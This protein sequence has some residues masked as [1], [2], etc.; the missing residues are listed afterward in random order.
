GRDWQGFGPK[1]KDAYVAGFIAGAAVRGT[2]AASGID[3]MP[4]KA[5]DAMRT[6][7]QMPF[8]FSVSVYASQIDDYYWW[9]NHL[10]IPIVDVMVRTNFQLHSH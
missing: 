4:S 3:T 5:I 1:E 2:A 7:K 9:E 10:D 6:A 8:P